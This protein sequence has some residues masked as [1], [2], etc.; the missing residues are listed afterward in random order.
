MLPHHGTN[1][2]LLLLSPWHNTLGLFGS[3]PTQPATPQLF[4]SR[5]T[6]LHWRTHLV[7]DAEGNVLV[8]RASLRAGQSSTECGLDC[9][10]MCGHCNSN[11][12]EQCPQIPFLGLTMKRMMQVELS[13][14]CGSRS[15]TYCGA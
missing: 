9:L 2:V 5:L 14:L 8:R 10:Y 3:H 11:E 4:S 13:V 1:A 12:C 15:S 7:D 6:T